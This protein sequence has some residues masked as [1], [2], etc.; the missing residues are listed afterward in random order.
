[1]KGRYAVLLA[2]VVALATPA[3]ASAHG[4]GA[5]VALDYRLVLDPATRALAGVSVSIFDGDRS[6]RVVVDR[7]LMVVQGDLGE[8]MLRISSSGAF[9]NRASVTAAAEKIVSAGRGWKRVSPDSSFTWHE[10]RLAPPPYDSGSTGPVAKFAIPARLNG[11]QVEIG[12][13]FVRYARPSIWPWAAVAAIVVA[14]LVAAL[15]RRSELRGQ[16]TTLLGALAGLA[17]LAT[18]SVFGAAD[19]PNGRVTWAQFVVAVA[20]AAVVYGVL[21]RLHGIRRVQLAG[22]IGLASAVVSLSYLSV[23]WHGVVISLLP[24]TA[25]RGLLVAGLITGAAAAVSSLGFEGPP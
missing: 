23:F 14:A 16:L 8:P 9:A 24:A 7:G 12:G 18:L 1:M 11:H 25:S 20:I 17:G 3:G 13:T 4:R 15:R 22:F 21:I 19:A 5:T 10:H 2:A 6:V